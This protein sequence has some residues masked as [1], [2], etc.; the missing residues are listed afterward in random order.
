MTINRNN[1][2]AYLLDY[3]EGN[4]DPLLTADLMAFLAENPEFEKYI[5]DYD[6]RISL[7]DTQFYNQKSQLKK[8]FPDLPEVT[9]GNFDEFCV[10]ACEGLLVENDLTRL[11]EYVTLHP[12]RQ[13]DLEL[14][15]KTKLQP[16]M[17]I[18]YT[19][20]NRL[21]KKQGSAKLRYLY[22]A[23]G[24]A[25]SISLLFLLVFREPA[26]TIYT[27]TVPVNSGRIEQVDQQPDVLPAPSETSQPSSGTPGREP[28]Q[29][30][31]ISMNPETAPAG[32]IREIS[33]D[34]PALARLEP[35]SDM[36]V[37][38]S[39]QPPPVRD[40]LAKT[41]VTSMNAI[42]NRIFT[43]NTFADTRMGNLLS[44]IDFW[45]TAKTA[46][47]GFNYLTEANISVDRI[48]DESGNLTSLLIQ[49]D[50][51]RITGKIK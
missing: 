13:R 30:P 1:F 33:P 50:S 14:Y 12:E 38:S 29:K 19:G 5:P 10:A 17:A 16:D 39:V 32:E 21:K 51:Y 44:R 6:T 15:R 40:H 9:A 37:F 28:Q 42:Q 4:L 23:M 36:K 26:G 22:Y 45:K 25:A 20:K 2:E 43:S 46:I 3:L 8:D 48:T 49:S 47:S 41:A 7:S 27:E 34:L 11:S 31:L 35:V 24:I 18:Q